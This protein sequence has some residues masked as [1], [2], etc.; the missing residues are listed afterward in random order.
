MERILDQGLDLFRCDG[1]ALRQTAYFEGNDREA[2]WTYD[3]NAADGQHSAQPIHSK[4]SFEPRMKA[5]GIPPAPA[6]GRGT[7]SIRIMAL[8]LKVW[9]IS[10]IRG[11]SPV[12]GHSK[13]ASSPRDTLR[14]GEGHA[15][16][17]QEEP[18]K[19]QRQFR[20]S[21]KS[22]R[23]QSNLIKLRTNQKALCMLRRC[24]LAFHPSLAWLPLR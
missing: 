24:P 17:T 5:V 14:W 20:I 16:V 9:M 1:A 6:L 18:S 7:A 10:F 15:T 13:A 2:A 19:T 21:T 4:R 11:V 3:T 12:G 8:A 23:W 22:V